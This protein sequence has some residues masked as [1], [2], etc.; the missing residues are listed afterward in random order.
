MKRMIQQLLTISQL[1]KYVGV[2]VRAVRHYHALGLLPEPSRDSSGYRR[3]GADAVIKLAR[4]K[5]LVEAGVPLSQVEALIQAQ[6]DTFRA[7]V[8]S[9]KS[10][11]AKRI[12]ELTETK[13]RLDT[14]QSGD[15]MFVSETVASYLDS[16][17][18]IGLSATMVSHERDA[19]I[20]ISAL[21]PSYADVWAMQKQAIIMKPAVASLYLRLDEARDWAS[22]DP[23]IAE[24]AKDIV[25]LS[26][27]DKGAPAIAGQNELTT[28][29]QA[30]SLISDHDIAAFPSWKQ[31]GDTIKGLTVI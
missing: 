10:D 18:H 31:L 22:N 17:R 2:T 3:Y 13:K 16:L 9:I 25:R 8:V 21:Y 27:Q 20:L 1:A 6:P 23:R 7:A 12:T 4:I 24:L 14:L 29:A 15:R 11:I 5:T 26:G 28:N 19:W 30:L